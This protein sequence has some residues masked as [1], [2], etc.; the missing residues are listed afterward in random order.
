MNEQERNSMYQQVATNL[1]NI[2][3]TAP[4]EAEMKSEYGK[5][6]WK[7]SKYDDDT[8][9]AISRADMIKRTGIYRLWGVSYPVRLLESGFLGWNEIQEDHH[10]DLRENIM[11]S[12]GIPYYEA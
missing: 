9:L 10:K 4:S 1:T 12:Y 8:C 7:P 11:T 2:K 3:R 6:W 5:Y